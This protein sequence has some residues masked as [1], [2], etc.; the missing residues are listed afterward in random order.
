VHREAEEPGVTEPVRPITVDEVATFWRDGVVCL[1]GVLDPASVIAMRPAVADLIETGELADLSAMGDSLAGRGEQVLTG[2]SPPGQ[3]GRF[4]SGV[5]HW[6]RHPEFHSFALRS[7]LPAIAAILLR[8]EHIRLWEDS[9]LVKEP[10]TAERTAWHQDLAYF[11]AE[12]EQ[13][14]TMWCPLDDVSAESGAVRF[15]VG[16]HRRSEVYQP[17]LFVSTMVIPGTE[18]AAVP[19]IDRQAELGEARIITFTTEPGDLTVHH[20][21][22]IHGAGANLGRSW[23][24]AIS[25]RYC[26]DDVTYRLKPGVPRKPHHDQVHDGDPLTDPDCPLAWPT[27]TPRETT[28][29]PS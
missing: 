27:P 23:R 10:G 9:V 20:A 6:R 17:N 15:V 16:S 28:A 21:R 4:V 25:V 2:G 26:G 18:G 13:L 11:H 8:S 7:P 24:R 29:A 5:D 19:D 14:C 3:R 1:R 12:G 22:T